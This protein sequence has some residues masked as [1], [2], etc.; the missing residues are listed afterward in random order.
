MEKWEKFITYTNAENKGILYEIHM[1]FEP[2]TEE[3][4]MNTFLF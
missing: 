2:N 4:L 3:N 1:F